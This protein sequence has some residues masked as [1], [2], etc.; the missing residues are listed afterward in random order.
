MDSLSLIVSCSVLNA[1]WTPSSRGSRRLRGLDLRFGFGSVL[2]FMLPFWQD[3]GAGRKGREF[4]TVPLP[5]Y[6]TA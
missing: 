3:S 2:D 6:L 5:A 1:L 4:Q